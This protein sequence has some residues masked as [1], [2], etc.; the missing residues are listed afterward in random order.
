MYATISAATIIIHVTNVNHLSLKCK[1]VH[2]NKYYTL[3]EKIQRAFERYRLSH[4]SHHRY[5]VI[6]IWSWQCYE[7][8]RVKK[9][10]KLTKEKLIKKTVTNNKQSEG[11]EPSNREVTS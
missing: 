10:A 9:I 6:N 7:S 2:F 3:N 1:Y 4:H 5:R 8:S 11:G